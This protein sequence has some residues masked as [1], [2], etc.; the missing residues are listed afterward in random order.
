[1]TGLA[2]R[3]LSL[4]RARTA[5]E[6]GVLAIGWGLGGQVGIGTL[7]YAVSIGPLAQFFLPAFTVA[8]QGAS[9]QVPIRLQA[10]QRQGACS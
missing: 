1:M 10:T 8:K 5:I 7:I 6:V 3:G 4:G 9:P 2:A